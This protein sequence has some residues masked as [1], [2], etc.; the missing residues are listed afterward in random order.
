MVTSVTPETILIFEDV[1]FRNN[2]Y[3]DSTLKVRRLRWI[4][5]GRLII[6]LVSTLS[7]RSQNSSSAILSR[8]PVTL[9][10][11]CFIDNSF[12][13]DAPVISFANAALD[14]SNNFVSPTNDDLS[15]LL[16]AT[17]PDQTTFENGTDVTC[18]TSDA[19]S[20]QAEMPPTSPSQPTPVGSPTRIPV[21]RATLA[22]VS[23]PSRS[24]TE[25]PGSSRTSASFSPFCAT[26]LAIIV[27]IGLVFILWV[28]KAPAFDISIVLIYVY[29]LQHCM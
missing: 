7:S 10:N 4:S 11:T 12:I 28:V 8:G 16:V 6:F 19:E 9:R 2:D 23:P 14:S 17:Y 25:A 24:P 3:G 29:F 21:P 15:C 26:Y 27:G 22:P 13:R 18:T 1:I 20:C 5:L